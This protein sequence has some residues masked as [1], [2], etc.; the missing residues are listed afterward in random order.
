VVGCSDNGTNFDIL[1]I[2]Y[3]SNAD[4]VWQKTYDSGRDDFGFGIA[5]DSSGNVYVS[6]YSYSGGIDYYDY[7]TIKYRQ[8]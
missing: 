7:L 8:Y 5:V 2:K 6:G 1:A 3:N 4:V